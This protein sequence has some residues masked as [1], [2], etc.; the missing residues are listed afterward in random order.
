MGNVGLLPQ[1]CGNE[2]D[3]YQP[4]VDPSEV[5]IDHG[6]DLALGSRNHE[7][8]LHDITND[9]QHQ[10]QHQRQHNRQQA[11]QKQVTKDSV[12]RREV[13]EKNKKKKKRKAPKVKRNDPLK[14]EPKLKSRRPILSKR[15]RTLYQKAEELG[16]RTG[17][18]VKVVLYNTDSKET[19]SYIST[20]TPPDFFL[21]ESNE[22]VDEL[23][24][25]EDD[26][27]DAAVVME[28]D[29]DEDEDEDDEEPLPSENVGNLQQMA[30]HSA[31]PEPP[32]TPR[33]ANI[34]SPATQSNSVPPSP[35]ARRVSSIASQSSTT[36][37]R[38]K[39]LKKYNKNVCQGCNIKYHSKEDRHM[40]SDSQKHKKICISG[41]HAQ[42][43]TVKVII[44]VM[45]YVWAPTPSNDFTVH[46]ILNLQGF[47]SFS[48]LVGRLM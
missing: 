14:Y 17:Y 4:Y 9:Q 12:V 1:W 38:P 45:L 15:K 40:T 8:P 6:Y 41:L 18:Y 19:K 43:L 10:H 24:S 27:A 31:S 42:R 26:N 33:R 28:E 46:G 34:N 29:V 21:K 20:S 2:P 7:Q 16:V 44:G 3:P 25:D 13:T 39:K 47:N 36:V 11:Q 32:Y 22:V 37:T 30:S 35:A 23:D 48:W 5:I